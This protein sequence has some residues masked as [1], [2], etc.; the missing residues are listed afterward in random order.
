MINFNVLNEA[1]RLHALGFAVIWI[2]PKSKIPVEAGWTTGPRKDL[3]YLKATYRE[4]M[5]LGVR[6]GTPSKIGNYYLA[7]IDVDVRNPKFKDVAVRY[8]KSLLPPGVVAPVV[9]SGR[10][11]GSRHYYVL[12]REPFKTVTPRKVKDAFEVAL[13]SNGR[14]VVLP[15]SIHPETGNEYRWGNPSA[16]DAPI[17]LVNFDAVLSEGGASSRAENS[18]QAPKL[19]DFRISP[20]ELAW[21][22]ISKQVLEA[23][24]DGK[25]VSDRSGYLLKASSALISAG[26]TENEVLTVLTNPKT[27]L[28]QC[29]YEHAKTSSRKR[30]AEWVYRY[31]FKKVE[32]ER[33]PG[34]FKD[35]AVPEPRKLSKEEQQAQANE[36]REDRPWTQDIIYT[37]AGI[38]QKLIQNVVT[39]ISGVA[40]PEVIQRDEFTYRDTYSYDTPWRGKKGEV[41]SDDDVDEIRYWLGK[42]FKFEPT[43]NV[44][45]S[46][47]IVLARGNAYDPVKQMLDELPEWDG[48]ERLNG[49]L[50]DNFEAEGDEEY[51][52]QVFRKWMV[53]MVMR[54]YRPGAKFDWMPIFEGAQGVGKSSFGRLLVGDKYFLDWLPPLH[55]KDSSLSLQGIWAVEMGELSQ[56]RRN[57]LETIKAF[58]TRTVDKMRPPYGKRLIESPR[59]CVFFGTT[60]RETYLIDETGNRRFKP[61]VVGRLNFK[62]LRRDRI[63]LFAEARHLFVTGKETERSLEITGAARTF[64]R[65]LHHEKMVEDD[66]NTMEEQ[67]QDFIEKVKKGDVNFDLKA[68][69]I[70]DLF[71][72]SGPF[73]GWRKENRNLQF[74]GKM[75]RRIGATMTKN[76]G[77]RRWKVDK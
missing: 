29:A 36:F 74:A 67:M 63:Q 77:V 68:F 66:S 73:G 20:V 2:R 8:A 46:A 26:L 14:Q 17:P 30:A 50:K 47:L 32:A 45:S 34:V 15:P 37:Q 49:W 69:R 57:E 41:V 28:G 61:V 42:N 11:N 13:Y 5:N 31:T 22:P 33:S 48:V 18:T 3:Q 19:E 4:G 6:L 60:N 43:E 53:A 7:V 39:V 12:T 51:L 44:V 21:L 40:G 24:R 52:A 75:L 10:G 35:L 56:F 62:A 64:E 70:L 71:S 59:R 76:H 16:F 23:I 58:I 1:A 55:D 54:V 65:A 72:G 38:P 27:F 25:N 9:F